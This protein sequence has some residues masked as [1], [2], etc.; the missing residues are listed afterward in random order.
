VRGRL[1]VIPALVAVVLALAI[2]AVAAAAW[3]SGPQADSPQLSLTSNQLN[4]Q[5]SEANK[6]LI[7]LSNAKPGQVA[8]GTTRVT[9]TG[10]T[11]TV[12]VRASN[13]RDLPGPNGGRLIASRRL[14]I[15]VRCVATPCP[16]NPAAYKGPLALMG[17]RSLGTWRPGTHRTYAVRV[18]LL[19]GG[20]PPSMISGDNLY[21]RSTARFGLVW[22][23]TAG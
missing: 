17:T 9:T 15:D 20:M 22:T 4:L 16:P 11:A 18:W 8:R 12:Q 3:R 21:Q 7:R 1:P 19:R 23:A 6:A 5:Q 2:A 14:W 10:A 13:L